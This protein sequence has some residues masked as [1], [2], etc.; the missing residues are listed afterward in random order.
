MINDFRYYN[1]FNKTINIFIY[2][3]YVCALISNLFVFCSFINGIMKYFLVSAMM[4]LLFLF[5]YFFKDKIKNIIDSLINRFKEY[6]SKKLLLII[7]V[8]AVL[9]KVIY[10]V[11]FYFDT[12]AYGGDIT[13]YSNIA[14]SIF[15]EGLGSV[16]DYIYYLVGMGIHLTVFKKLSLSYHIGM[17]IIFL[18]GTIINYISF[19]RLIGKEKSFLLIMMYIFM[20]STCLLTFCITHELFGYFY[21]SIILFLIACFINEKQISNEILYALSI[22]LFVSLNGTVS[23]MGKIWFIV[24]AILIMLTNLNKRKKIIL[25]AVLV[26]TFVTTNYLS[27]KLEGNT[28]SQSNNYEQLLIGS[29]LNSMGRHTDGRGRDAAREYWEARGVEL[30]YENLVEGEKGALIEQYK[31]LITHPVDLFVLLANKFY[32]VWSGDYYSVEFAYL[33]GVINTPT[34]YVML[35]ISALIWLTIMSLSVVYYVKKEE[36]IGINTY[37]LIILGIMAVLLITEVT[38]KYSCYMTM[39]IYFIA[40]ARTNLGGTSNE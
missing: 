24:L 21:F 13:V 1:W 39:F 34:Y 27:T 40:V 11:F 28:Q 2:C 15:N 22:L 38:N 4:I 14:D 37:K 20:P 10:S 30:T 6:N 29:D 17:F 3:F 18:I 19:S 26:L 7:I 16:K 23:P 33:C 36:N 31:Y 12:T 25:A 32:V 9:L 35:I 5:F 8:V